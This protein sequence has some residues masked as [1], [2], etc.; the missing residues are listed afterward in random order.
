M[1]RE[2]MLQR[3]AQGLGVDLFPDLLRVVDLQLPLHYHFE[4]GAADD[5]VTVLIPLAALGQL[6]PQP[7]EWLVP[8]MLRD[9]ITALIRALPK[10]LRVNFVPAPNFAEAAL[11]GMQ[12]GNGQLF[13]QLSHRLLRISGTNVPLEIWRDCELPNHLQMNFRILGDDGRVWGEGRDL[14]ELQ[15]RL[16]GKVRATLAQAPAPGIER[17]NIT[18]WDFGDLPEQV[19][20]RP[21]GI[22]VKAWPALVDQGEHVA[23]RLF[24]SA[25]AADQQMRH[26]VRRLFLRTSADKVKYLRSHLP[27]L[28]TMCLHYVGIGSCDELRED[29]INAAVDRALELESGALPRSADEFERRAAKARQSLIEV[30]NALCAT[31]AEVL[32]LHHDISKVMRGSVAPTWLPALADIGEQLAS[33]NTPAQWLGHYPRYLRAIIQRLEKL[34]QSPERD[35]KLML[36]VA[37]HW[38]R[39]A[40]RMAGKTLLPVHL[41][42]Y[43]WMVEELRVSLFAQE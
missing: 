40:E 15:E 34:R 3:E 1:T 39:V 31:V 13:E 11:E 12:F 24:E 16:S 32:R 9:K 43:R 19:E 26:G 27:G 38:K 5:G 41:E 14:R 37:P 8:G 17:D 4:P 42:N 33:I 18:H 2:D 7:F 28:Q 22:A 6:T 10:G 25:A 35:R 21:Q 36:E 29:L 30:A 20:I 23:I